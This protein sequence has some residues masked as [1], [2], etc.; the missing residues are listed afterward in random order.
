MVSSTAAWAAVRDLHMGGLELCDQVALSSM[1]HS[2]AVGA[3]AAQ[4]WCAV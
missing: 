4:G 2:I 3:A 1:C